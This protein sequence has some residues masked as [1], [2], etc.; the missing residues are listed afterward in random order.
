MISDNKIDNNKRFKIASIKPNGTVKTPSAK[1][2]N[3][4]FDMQ[5]NAPELR[6]D[7]YCLEAIEDLSIKKLINLS[8]NVSDVMK[9]YKEALGGM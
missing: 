9:E 5:P 1:L 7:P 8:K 4:S 2:D 6:I 3:S